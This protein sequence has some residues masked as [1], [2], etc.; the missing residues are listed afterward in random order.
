MKPALG[1]LMM[2]ALSMISPRMEALP[3]NALQTGTTSPDEN[4]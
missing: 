3:P 4:T 2:T 1:G